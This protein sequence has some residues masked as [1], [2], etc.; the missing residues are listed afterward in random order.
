MDNLNKELRHNENKARFI[1]EIIDKKLNIMNVSEEIITKELE[2]RGYDKENK[3]EV[4]NEEEIISGYNYLLKLQVRTFTVEKVS[5]LQNEITTLKNK[6]KK[7]K[8]TTEKKMWL[9][10]LAEFETEYKKWEKIMNDNDNKETKKI[11]KK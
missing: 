3:K 4:E 2:K 6:I 8:G 1:Q 9:N 10:D 7:I 11:K 5:Q